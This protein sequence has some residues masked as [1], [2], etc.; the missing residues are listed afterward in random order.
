[1][2]PLLAPDVELSE[3]DVTDEEFTLDMRVVEDTTPL[4]A[5]MCSTGDGCGAT[6]GGSACSTG[7]NDPS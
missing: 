5:M 2:A 6:C 3:I 4:V 1:M 7:S